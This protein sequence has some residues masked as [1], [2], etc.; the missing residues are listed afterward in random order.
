[1]YKKDHSELLFYILRQLSQD[2]LTFQR[3]TS[4]MEA[5]TIEIDEK[6]LLDKVNKCLIQLGCGLK[7]K[8]IILQAKQIDIHDLKPFYESKIFK[9]NDFVY[10]A[11]RK[12]II[13][14]VPETL[15]RED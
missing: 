14:T 2:Q 4:D 5:L 11:K 13:H 1:M 10:D 9:S 12:V 6:D 8:F 7:I 3:G 15:S